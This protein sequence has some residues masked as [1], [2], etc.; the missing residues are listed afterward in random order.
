MGPG[1]PI[2]TKSNSLGG[3]VTAW[4]WILADSERFLAQIPLGLELIHHG[5]LRL[6]WLW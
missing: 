4:C 1:V 2:P 5:G 6:G 3:R